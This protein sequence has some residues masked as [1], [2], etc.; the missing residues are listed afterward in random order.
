MSQYKVVR[1][2]SIKTTVRWPKCF[3]VYSDLGDA[4][5]YAKKF[6]KEGAPKLKIVNIETGRTEIKDVSLLDDAAIGRFYE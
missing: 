1:K 5:Q 2:T 3:G 4:L 6:L